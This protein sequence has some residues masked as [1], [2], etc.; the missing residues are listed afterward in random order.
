MKFKSLRRS[1]LPVSP[2]GVKILPCEYFRQTISTKNI[3]PKQTSVTSE[4]R[5]T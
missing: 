1:I 4:S 5:A 2:E 3:A